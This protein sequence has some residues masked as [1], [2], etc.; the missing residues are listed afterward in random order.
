[1]KGYESLVT[2]VNGLIPSITEALPA[3]TYQLRET[4]LNNYQSLTAHI[5]FTIGAN[6]LV[7]LHKDTDEAAITGKVQEDGSY[8]YTL[9]I[10]NTP[11]LVSFEKVDIADTKVPLAGAQ[12]ELWS[13]KNGKKDK[14]IYENLT[15][16]ENGMLTLEK[17]GTTTNV[18]NLAK[19]TYQLI[20]TKAPDGYLMKTKPVTV[21]VGGHG[22]DAVSYDEGTTL[23]SG[24][25]GLSYD[26]TTHIFTL[27]ISNTSGAVLPNT[28]GEG[29]AN[30]R[31]LG[32]ILLGFA[33]LSFAALTVLRRR[34]WRR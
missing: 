13:D 3:G 21:T 33:V 16:D 28:G 32:G 6:G 19:G 4:A 25:T 26:E 24:K 17:D 18:F 9:T 10:E 2:D 27:K 5:E 14:K 15:S 7:T 8:A 29:T 12:F 20:E 1:M 11:Y 31:V 22:K 23:S 30:L 34:G